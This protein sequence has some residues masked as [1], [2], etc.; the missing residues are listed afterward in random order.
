MIINAMKFDCCYILTKVIGN[1]IKNEKLKLIDAK[2]VSERYLIGMKLP[3]SQ[4]RFWISISA[5]LVIVV[6]CAINLQHNPMVHTAPSAKPTPQAPKLKTEAIE[7]KF[8]PLRQQYMQQRTHKNDLDKIIAQAQKL[9][10]KYPDFAPG[11]LFVGQL[12][13]DKGDMKNAQVYI[14]KSLALDPKQGQVHLLAGNIA[15]MQQD[16]KRAA[17]HLS[18]AVA[19]KPS[20]AQYWLY[21]GE[22]YFAQKLWSEAQ[23]CFEK[24]LELDSDMT[25]AYAGIAD[26][27]VK[28]GKTREAVFTMQRAIDQTPPGKRKQQVIYL[29]K[30]AKLL[31][32]LGKPNEALVVLGKLTDKEKADPDVMAEMSTYWDQMGEPGKAA[33]VYEVQ[34][35]KDL[36]NWELAAAAARWRLKARDYQKAREHIIHLQLINPDLPVIK[37]LEME[38][39]SSE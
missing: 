2:F 32:D 25:L 16:P 7:Q 23:Q 15:L 19:L 18:L 38:L 8:E 20:N 4:V 39:P 26:C 13:F 27:Q 36:R 14:D 1:N 21:L 22:S 29:R 10:E 6:I 17:D 24:A 3:N 33:E 9:A 37:E 5:M 28:Q 12:Y 34:L 31:A 35:K 30:Q 11:Q